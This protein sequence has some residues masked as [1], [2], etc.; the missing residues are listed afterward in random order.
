[1]EFIFGIGGRKLNYVVTSDDIL[2]QEKTEFR[3]YVGSWSINTNLFVGNLVDKTDTDLYEINNGYIVFK[4]LDRVNQRA[5]IVYNNMFLAYD[6]TLE[7]MDHSLSFALTDVYNDG[8]Q[9]VKIVPAQLD[10]WLNGHPLIDNVDW[11]FKDKRFYIHNK[12]FLVNGAQKITVRAHQFHSDMNVP[13]TETELGFVNGGVIG[14]GPRYNVRLDR[15]TRCVVY[16][17]LMDT[18]DWTEAELKG[19]YD[20]NNVL[21][22]RPYM[23]KHSYTPVMYARPYDMHPLYDE[24]REL[25]QRVSD[26]LTANIVKP[27]ATV[28]QNLQDKYRLFSPFLNAIVNNIL[29]NVILLPALETGKM[30]SNQTVQDL[31][32]PFKSWLDVDPAQLGFDLRYF[33]IFPYANTGPLT[34]T[35]AQLMFIRQANDLFLN[36]S[37][38]IESHFEVS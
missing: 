11:F 2:L 18:K 26:Y 35:A 20:L 1:M 12:E 22:G 3:V 5:M 13:K 32:A 25:D 23:I 33:A 37:A 28:T 16:G 34:V 10:L 17:K 4:T 27:A 31:C 7:H 24:A 30:Y 19:P 8:R 6:F 14:D 21:N 29:N 36:S 38:R 9:Q 15:T